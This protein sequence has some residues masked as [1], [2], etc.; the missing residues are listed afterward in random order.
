MATIPHTRT[1]RPALALLS[2]PEYDIRASKNEVS[3][4]L[5][6]A[7]LPT[8]VQW[9]QLSGVGET[10]ARSRTRKRTLSVREAEVMDAVLGLASFLSEGEG[11]HKSPSRPVQSKSPAVKPKSKPP[12]TQKPLPI[13]SARPAYQPPLGYQFTLANYL[14]PYM[15]TSQSLMSLPANLFPYMM[16]PPG[17]YGPVWMMPAQMAGQG[18]RGLQPIT[19]YKRAA[20]HAEI[21]YFIRAEV[22]KEKPAEDTPVK[23]M[24]HM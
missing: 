3:K 22:G 8:K 5:Q 17:C 4:D 7:C 15:N 14:Y 9:S 10:K 18:S 20:R 23:Y 19:K 2:L 13:A 12:P 6:L 16:Y 24:K 1:R 21:A 11:P